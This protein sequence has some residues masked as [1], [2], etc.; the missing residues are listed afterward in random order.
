[1]NLN[2]IPFTDVQTALTAADVTDRETDKFNTHFHAHAEIVAAIPEPKD[3]SNKHVYPDLTAS[4]FSHW[5][6]LIT[7]SQGFHD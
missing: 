4:H 2:I 6:D 1:M 7:S 3:I 5:I